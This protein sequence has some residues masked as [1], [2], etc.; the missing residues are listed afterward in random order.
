MGTNF[1]W[2]PGNQ[3]KT[4]P[5]CGRG[6]AEI[7]H[8]IGKRSFGWTFTFQTCPALGVR[9]FADWKRVFESDPDG[10][11]E[12][13]HGHWLSNS[14]FISIVVALSISRRHHASA[15]PDNSYSD[16][17]GHSFTDNDFS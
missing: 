12:D 1:Y 6:D 4:C 2:L 11:I 17:E 10:Y 5:T 9:S 3:P 16:P 15:H 14:E 13:E 7:R 8:H